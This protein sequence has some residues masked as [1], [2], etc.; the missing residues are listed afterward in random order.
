[1]PRTLFRNIQELWGAMQAP[2]KALRGSELGQLEPIK[3]AYLLVEEGK[4]AAYGPMSQCPE[5]ADE[6]V[7]V[8]GK[9]ML[10][11]F[12]DSHTHLVY[13]KSR[14]EEFVGKIKGLSYE[15]IARKGGGILNSARVLQAS[16]ESLLYERAAQRLEEV[17]HLGTGAIEIKSGYGLSLD[18]ELKSLRVIRRLAESYKDM[19]IRSTFLGAHAFPLEYRERREDYISLI[20]E[21][22]LPRVADEGLADYCDV[23]CEEGFFTQAETE[24]ILAA[25]SKYGLRAKVHA[26]ELA[27]SGGVQAGVQQQ[28]ISVD[29]LE[30]IGEEELALLGA[31]DTIASLLP[32]TAFFL[33]L[34]YAPAR[35]L[36]E[37]GAAIALASDY[38]PGTTP[39]GRMAFVWS[40]ACIYM[41]M[42]PEEALAALTIN[43][44]FAMDLGKDYGSLSVG[45]VANLLITK[46]IP[47]LAFIPYSFG[48]DCIEQVYLAGRPL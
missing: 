19:P 20:T 12:C 7:S 48:S 27:F 37:A 9:T 4:V 32:S 14:E 46:E 34:P 5:R 33:R 23:F 42:L 45:K 8:E 31:S 41:R 17:R 2:Q 38:N 6:I 43:G 3:N 10:P 35:K 13:A 11:A 25:A 36:I 1:M 24:R 29:H 18:A 16:D 44:A 30:C 21:R 15:E 26:N 40:L 39:S 28:A 47:S 22:M